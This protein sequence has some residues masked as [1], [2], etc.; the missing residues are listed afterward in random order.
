M[1]LPKPPA[2][3]QGVRIPSGILKIVLR[4]I[5]FFIVA[6]WA[7]TSGGFRI[8][9]GT[10]VWCGTIIASGQWLQMD[11]RFHC[12]YLKNTAYSIWRHIWAIIRPM[13]QSGASH[14]SLVFR[15]VSSFV[16]SSVWSLERVLMA[17]VAAYRVG[18]SGR[19][20]L[21]ILSNSTDIWCWARR[22]CDS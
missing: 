3:L 8:V 2:T 10:L 14:D 18:Y 11:K 1:P 20:D 12:L 5:L 22:V 19:T 7:L 9:F 6:V 21:F 16:C 15:F 4:L 13:P 17:A